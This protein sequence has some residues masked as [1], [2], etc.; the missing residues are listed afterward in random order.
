[1]TLRRVSILGLAA[2]VILSA[3]ATKPPAAPEPEPQTVEPVKG[4]EISKE[5]LDALHGRVLALRKEAFELGLKDSMAED[6]AA[7]EAR[8]VAGKA[9]LDA[10]DRP[11]AMAEL[12]AAEPL[13]ADLVSKGGPLAAQNRKAAA[14]DSRQRAL[15]ADAETLSPEALAQADALLVAADAALAAGDIRGAIDAYGLAIA[16]F[17]AVE[18]RSTA[19]SVKTTVDNLEYGP[20]D[21]GNYELA[22]QKL[23][24]VDGLMATDPKA[25]GDAADESLLRYRLVLSKGWELTAGRNRSAAERFKVDA[26][27]IKA[28]V[29]V[30]QG[31]ADAKAVWDAAVAASAS[32]DN[33]AAAPLFEKS[34]YLFQEVYELAATKRAAAVAA[35]QA[36]GDKNARS[37]TIAEKG[38]EAIGTDVLD[39]DEPVVE[40]P[41]TEGEEE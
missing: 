20:M 17:D 16:A 30:K 37:A 32:G 6:Y 9:A 11:T 39:S 29:A 19:V 2:A 8:Y 40:A 33:E 18:K 25:A 12:G 23:A 15:N 5:D 27:A 34:E 4:P 24:A 31:Y 7:A 21:A 35:I 10:D 41:A 22:G 14:A 38:D 36:A 3:C 1:M 13:F 28:Q 26:E